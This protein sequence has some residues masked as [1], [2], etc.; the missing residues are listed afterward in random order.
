MAQVIPNILTRTAEE[1]DQVLLLSGKNIRIECLDGRLQC[2]HD[3][4]DGPEL[5]I[6]L[7]IL[8]QRVRI[9]ALRG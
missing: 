2:G 4:G 7:V 1:S 5:P 6:D 9:F 3:G 8:P